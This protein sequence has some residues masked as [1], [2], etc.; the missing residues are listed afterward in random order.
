MRI[1][2]I[3]IIGTGHISEIYCSNLTTVHEN[4]EIVAVADPLRN[5]LNTAK[6]THG[7]DESQL[8]TDWKEIKGSK[9]KHEY[10]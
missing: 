1:A 2:K 8:Y 5:R 4:T 7:L 3:G 10:R 6:E 9:N